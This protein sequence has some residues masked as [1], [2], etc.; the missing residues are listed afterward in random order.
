MYIV[1]KAKNSLLHNT[2]FKR[3]HF[4]VHHNLQTVNPKIPLRIPLSVLKMKVEFVEI[5]LKAE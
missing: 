3:R 1:R 4:Y 2:N 5:K